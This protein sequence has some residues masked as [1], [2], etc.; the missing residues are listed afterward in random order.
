MFL[1][2]KAR[3]YFYIYSHLDRHTKKVVQAKEIIEKFLTMCENH[4]LSWSTGKDSTAVLSILRLIDAEHKIPVVHFDLGVE[5]P[6][7][8]EYKK[9]FEDVTTF[10]PKETILEVMDQYG[11]EAKE[12]KKINF[13]NQFTEKKNYDGHMMGLRYDESSARKNLFKRG[14]IYKRKDGLLV[15]NP[16]YNWTLEDVFAYLISSDVPIHPHYSIKSNQPLEHRRVGG[17]VSGRNRGS[18][19][20]RFYWFKEQYPDEF[21]KLSQKFKEVETYV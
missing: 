4:Y 14:P 6:G 5:L 20:G 15:C 19:F 3:E 13:I 2:D 7:T 9:N 12:A 10:K 8:D 16:I 18:E 11:W 17:Y 21:E 1:D